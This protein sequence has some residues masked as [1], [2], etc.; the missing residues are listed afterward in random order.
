MIPLL[1]L[2]FLYSFLL[3]SSNFCIDAST[4]SSK[5]ASPL[6]PFFLT[7]VV[8]QCHLW[9]MK[10]SA[11]LSISLILL[12]KLTRCLFFH[13][14]STADLGLEFSWSYKVLFYYFFFSSLFDGVFF[15]YFQKLVIFL[16]SKHLDV[17][18]V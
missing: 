6:P 16:L 8:C 9:S 13:E 11:W 12:W 2:V 18:L 10:P 14:I 7:H 5:L 3:Y 17:F 1:Q 4:Q 15:Q